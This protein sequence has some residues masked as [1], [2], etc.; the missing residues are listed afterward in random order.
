MGRKNRRKKNGKTK[1]LC[2]YG[3]LTRKNKTVAYCKLHNCYLE[4]KDIK[5]K[6]CNH[7]NCVHIEEIL[8][9]SM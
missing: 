2:M 9:R 6:R 1:N 8:E 5:E 3:R 7:K 4:P